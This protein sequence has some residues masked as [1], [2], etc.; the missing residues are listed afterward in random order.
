ML[1]VIFKDLPP[2]NSLINVP[3]EQV[4]HLVN[5]RRARVHDEIECMD[6]ENNYCRA[7]IEIIEKNEVIIC[8]VSKIF[9]KEELPR[10][11]L[12]SALL[13]E[14][15]LDWII[16]KCTEIGVAE[17]MPVLSEH[18]TAKFHKKSAD[19][20]MERW[21]KISEEAAKQCG[22]KPMQINFPKKFEEALYFDAKI[23]IICE[24]NAKNLGF[25]FKNHKNY[26]KNDKIA[27][28][29]GPEGGFSKNEV[30]LAINNGWSAV[31]FHQNI[32]RAETAAVVCCSL[33]QNKV[34]EM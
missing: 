9:T 4:H 26:E 7:R 3:D 1:R 33:I 13:P 25:F 12:F 10:I 31:S 24:K 21:K 17:F 34:T 29:I 27:V 2:V 11:I 16:Q 5:V 32:L 6:Y 14:K 15:K 28:L 18:C 30:K 23:K 22:G 20:K 19:K 8:I